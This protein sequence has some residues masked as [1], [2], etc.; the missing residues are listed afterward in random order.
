MPL[1]NTP[2]YPAY[3]SNYASA[4]NAARVVL[5]EAYGNGHH[6]FVV[7][8]TNPAVNVTLR[9]TRIS[10]LVNDIEEARIDGGVHYR[11]DMDAGSRQGSQVGSYIVEHLLRPVHHRR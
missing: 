11:F 10:R 8:S 5:Q 4:A 7:K 2:P 3:T 1:I 6:S 9:Y